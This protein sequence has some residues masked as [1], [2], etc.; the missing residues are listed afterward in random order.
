MF[1]QFPQSKMNGT[2]VLLLLCVMV[3][4]GVA[5]AQDRFVHE[6]IESSAFN[7][8]MFAMGWA[9]TRMMKGSD[10]LGVNWMKVIAAVP[11]ALRA[12]T[13]PGVVAVKTAPPVAGA[14]ACTAVEPPMGSLLLSPEQEDAA[15]LLAGLCSLLAWRISSADAG[16]L[17][18]WH[19]RSCFHSKLAI[20]SH[21]EEYLAHLDWFFECSSPCLVIALIYFDRVLASGSKITLSVDTC[22]RLFLTS[23]VVATKFHDD[24]YTPY[25]N[26]FYA[27]VGGVSVEEMNA[28]EKS[29]CKSIDWHFY[30]EPKEFLQYQELLAT[31]P[32]V[33]PVLPELTLPLQR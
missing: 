4:S 6:I 3:H 30:V 14:N 32:F 33:L 8:A 20:D 26:A 19:T 22:H 12:P 25:P 11:L 17:P 18:P 21:L 13:R 7:V 28:M 16:S 23:L 27:D 10:L 31:A 1:S 9:A 29:F 24:D 5:Y 15:P 2:F